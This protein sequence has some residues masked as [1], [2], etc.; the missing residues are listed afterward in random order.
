MK[1][2]ELT[3]DAIVYYKITTDDI[4]TTRVK[5]ISK[6]GDVLKIML[7]RSDYS[8][9]EFLCAPEDNVAMLVGEYNSKTIYFNRE[10]AEKFQLRLRRDTIKNA[11][12]SLQKALKCYNEKIDKYFNKPVSVPVSIEFYEKSKR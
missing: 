7:Q 11:H 12:D 3:I 6:K 8:S 1:A 10:D 9:D 2:K 5:S 4:I